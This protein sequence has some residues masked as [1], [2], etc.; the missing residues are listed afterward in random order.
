M[1]ELPPPEPLRFEDNVAE[2]WIRF[3]QRVELY[4]TATE[5]SEP[6]KQRSPA[7]KAAILLHLAGQEAIDVHNTFDL[8][9]EEK[10]DYDKLVQAFEAY[11]DKE[12]KE[13]R[14][15]YQLHAMRCGK[16]KVA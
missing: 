15:E 6:G 9:G 12:G 2:N 8:T 10:Q 14:M 5:S 13:S 3:K 1:T 4:F 7:Q 11:C 16:G